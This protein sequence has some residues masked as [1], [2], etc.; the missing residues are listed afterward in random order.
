MA[1]LINKDKIK[2]CKQISYLSG[3]HK[4]RSDNIVYLI[5]LID[6][7]GL[8]IIKKDSDKIIPIIILGIMRV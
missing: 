1:K 6:K 4:V 3:K 7:H 5:W 2:I 8:E